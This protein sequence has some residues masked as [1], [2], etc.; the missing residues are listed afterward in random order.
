MSMQI[1]GDVEA[2]RL[3]CSGSFSKLLTTYVCL[4]LLSEQYALPAI[5]D[6]D[7]FLDTLCQNDAS[8]HFLHLFQRL[9]GNRFSIRDVC[10]FYAGLPYTFD[11]SQAE[12]DI[13][14]SGLPFKH[15]SIPDEKMLLHRCE[16]L[17]TPLYTNQCKFHYS[18]LSIIFLGYLL[19]QIYGIKIESLYE[20]Y[21]LTQFKLTH[22]LFSRKLVPELYCQDLSNDYDYPSIAILNHGYFCYSNGFFT[23]LNEMKILLEGLITEPVFAIMTDI[24]QARAASNTIMNG[25]TIEIRRVQDDII[26]GYEGLSFSGCNIW[27]YSTKHKQ[28]YLTFTNNEEQAYPII[29]DNW[30]YTVFDK[31]PEHTQRIYKKFIQSYH[32]EEVNQAIPLDYRGEYLRVRINEYE[33]HTR[34]VVGDHFIIIRDPDEVKYEVMFAKGYYNVRGKDNVPGA[35]IGFIQSNSGHRYMYHDGT[36]YQKI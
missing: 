29:Y 22:S 13:V 9:I 28:G 33:L 2:N 24:T 34:F 7:N 5:L 20:K 26:Y 23:T 11:V 3:F 30:N 1:I 17:I 12:L 21:L 8:R 16:A 27:A 19:E 4:S 10:T 18:E 36:L 6:D 15:H 25:L 14:E 31:V 32:Y 35:K